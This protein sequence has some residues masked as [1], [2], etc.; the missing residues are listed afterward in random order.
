MSTTAA[1]TNDVVQRT[2][3]YVEPL[4]E[5]LVE[6]TAPL[7]ESVATTLSSMGA[8]T[9]QDAAAAAAPPSGSAAPTAKPT[10]TPTAARSAALQALRGAAASAEGLVR[11]SKGLVEV[12]A[13]ERCDRL[14]VAPRD[15]HAVAFVV[16]PGAYLHWTFRVAEADIGVALRECGAGEDLVPL[17]RFAAGES[18]SGVW[19]AGAAKAPRRVAL[20]FDNRYSILRQ[21]AVAF[22]AFVARVAPAEP[23]A[24][25][26]AE[27]PAAPLCT[28]EVRGWKFQVAAPAGVRSEGAAAGDR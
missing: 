26:P 17:G 24:E 20:S 18:H 1:K 5:P 25:S 19:C 23:P 15:E 2:I 12:L 4:V 22:R 9:R 21:K 7:R 10:A 13:E 8:L 14:V 27:P 11:A 3:D 28:L 16:E 6:R